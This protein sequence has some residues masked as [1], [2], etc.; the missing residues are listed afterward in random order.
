MGTIRPKY[1]AVYN[2][3]PL[4]FNDVVDFAKKILSYHIVDYPDKEYREVVINGK[5]TACYSYSYSEEEIEHDY[6]RA[7]HGYKFFHDTTYANM[8]YY[9]LI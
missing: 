3:V 2:G 1:I 5:V 6:F 9:S 8:Y 7:N 4:P